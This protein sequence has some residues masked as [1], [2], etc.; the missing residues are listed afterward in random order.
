MTWMLAQSEIVSPSPAPQSI[1][2]LKAGVENAEDIE[3]AVANCCPH[4]KGSLIPH[5]YQKKSFMVASHG[6]SSPPGLVPASL[7]AEKLEPTLKIRYHSVNQS[8]HRRQSSTQRSIRVPTN[9][10]SAKSA[11]NATRID[12]NSLFA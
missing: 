12:R 9:Q 1:P 10:I 2:E 11:R 5:R 8:R 7:T 3:E 6:F 4:C